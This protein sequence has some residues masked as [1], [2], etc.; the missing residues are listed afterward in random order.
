M[1]AA[2]AAAFTALHLAANLRGWY[3]AYWWIDAV[4]HVG[5][6]IWVAWAAWAYRR[7]VPGYGALPAWAQALGILAFVA[8]VGIL[9]ELYEAMADAWL[10]HAAGVPWS[11]VPE[12]FGMPPYDVRWDTLWDLANDLLGG[13]VVAACAL[14]RPGSGR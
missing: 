4:A 1:L 9:W 11:G 5:G 13:L 10:I 6:G 3:G 12:A 2:Y 14:L 7:R 8:L